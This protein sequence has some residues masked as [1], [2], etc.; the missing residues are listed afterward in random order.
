MCVE[1]LQDLVAVLWVV[2]QEDDFRQF[3]RVGAGVGVSERGNCRENGSGSTLV[4]A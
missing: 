4:R 2:A 1:A 3:D